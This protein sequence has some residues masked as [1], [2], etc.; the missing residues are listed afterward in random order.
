MEWAIKAAK[1][2]ESIFD[3]CV[4]IITGHIRRSPLKQI[5]YK[6][7]DRFISLLI[8]TLI[9]QKIVGFDATQ[10]N[11]ACATPL[12]PAPLTK[13]PVM[14]GISFKVSRVRAYATS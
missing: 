7:L 6:Q 14:F 10:R 3:M 13:I 1:A 9:D 2:V 12:R 5:I 8:R 4:E 11:I